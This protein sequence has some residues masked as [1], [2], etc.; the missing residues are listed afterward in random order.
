MVK[1]AVD[2]TFEV[3]KM[4]TKMGIAVL[5][6]AAA[7][8]AAAQSS[9][10][11]VTNADLEKYKQKRLAAEKDYREN[12]ARMGFPSPEELAEQIEKS[13]QELERT[14][15]IYRRQRLL[16]QQ[17]AAP[18]VTYFQ[19]AP[20]ENM[21]YRGIYPGIYY[22]FGFGYGRYGYPPPNVRPQR[23]RYDRPAA[24]WLPQ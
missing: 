15:E 6:A 16:Q 4:L 14:S 10:K 12:Y 18:A 3:L 20:P 11:V 8:S 24:R 7:V 13:R 9:G 23:P 5:I 17:S 2:L 1:Y 19:P 22:P 21:N